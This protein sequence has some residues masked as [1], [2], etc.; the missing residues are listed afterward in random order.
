MVKGGMKRIMGRW[1]LAFRFRVVC[2][3]WGQSQEQSDMFE[4]EVGISRKVRSMRLLLNAKTD[5]YTAPH[6]EASKNN[7]RADSRTHTR[8][9]VEE[10]VR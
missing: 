2:V 4:N 1:L 6:T 7:L 9:H 10:Q 8:T 3:T 5:M